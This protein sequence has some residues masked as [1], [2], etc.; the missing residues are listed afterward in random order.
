MVQPRAPRSHEVGGPHHRG[1]QRMHDRRFQNGHRAEPGMLAGPRLEVDA[2]PPRF[3]QRVGGSAHHA[4]QRLDAV[5]LAQRR[6]R[7]DRLDGLPQGIIIDGLGQSARESYRQL[8]ERHDL[9]TVPTPPRRLEPQLAHPQPAVGNCRP[10]LQLLHLHFSA[11][12]FYCPYRQPLRAGFP[13]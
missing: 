5:E 7:Q 8:L 11:H 9:E 2:R 6:L 13:A 1:R 10:T 4:G 3:A 12:S